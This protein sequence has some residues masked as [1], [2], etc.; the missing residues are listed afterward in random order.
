[1][2]KLNW[3]QFFPA[4]YLLDTHPLSASSRG[5]WMDIICHLWRSGTR[6][7]MTLSQAQWCKLLRVSVTQLSRAVTELCHNRI[8]DIVTTGHEAV[9]F[10][11]RRMIREEK[12]RNSATIR[13]RRHRQSRSVTPPSRDSHRENQNQK[14]NNTPTPVCHM[15]D[16]V[17]E[18]FARLGILSEVEHES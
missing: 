11:S 5:I 4:D 1:M 3:M 6:G 13:Q 16:E 14:Q 7:T 18:Q 10:T 12:S 15:P 2:G 17:R 9:T 8:C